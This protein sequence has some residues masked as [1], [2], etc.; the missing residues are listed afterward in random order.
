MPLETTSFDAAEHLDDL[1]GQADLVADALQL[2][3][4]A[5]LRHALITVARAQEMHGIGGA[6]EF[7]QRSVE[8]ALGA[9]TGATVQ[10]VVQV[11]AALGLELTAQIRREARGDSLSGDAA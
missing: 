9:G 4:D 8:R 3:D 7:G 11:M 6:G 1:Q 2:G 5:Y 10:S